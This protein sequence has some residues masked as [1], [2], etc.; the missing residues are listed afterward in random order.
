MLSE[1]R[2]R[3]ARHIISSKTPP[4]NF[5]DPL[6]GHIG[7]EI[8]SSF[9]SDELRKYDIDIITSL[10]KM[11]ERLYLDQYFYKPVPI[12]GI[13]DVIMS[14]DRLVR[15]GSTAY[16]LPW[17]HLEEEIYKTLYRPY[18]KIPV[19]NIK[20]RRGILQYNYEYNG[21]YHLKIP[22]RYTGEI[23]IELLKE[24]VETILEVGGYLII[25][26]TYLHTL[27]DFNGILTRLMKYIEPISRNTL[28]YIDMHRA[29][30]NPLYGL[31]VVYASEAISNTIMNTRGIN[32]RAVM[33]DRVSIEIFTLHL[34]W[35]E[36][37]NVVKKTLKERKNG[38]K[39]MLDNISLES[40]YT[41]TISIN[42][43]INKAEELLNENILVEPTY[44]P[45]QGI[46]LDLYTDTFEDEASEVLVHKLKV[47]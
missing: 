10:D 11:G 7:Y 27:E 36:Y 45:I 13:E 41:I 31:A 9:I 23:Y 29:H 42:D 3:V 19:E 28:F 12:N 20:P 46:T 30:V 39:K 8:L 40:S 18:F 5:F 38:L 17:Y 37:I 47:E 44:E 4:L 26:I 24:C 1:W 33:D 32:Y 14:I 22:D 6:Y 21:I 43:P 25:D 15:K 16:I 35:T 34:F 2:G